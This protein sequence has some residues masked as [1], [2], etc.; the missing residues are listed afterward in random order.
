MSTSEGSAG[1]GG[2]I[3]LGGGG[4]GGIYTAGNSGQGTGG[5]LG[6]DA[7]SAGAGGNAAG[8]AGSAGSAGGSGGAGATSPGI[9]VNP[10]S[11]TLAPGGTQTFSCTVTGLQNK[12]C[13]WSVK[14]GATGGSV[15]TGGVYAAP[16]QQGTYHVVAASH[17]D[18]ALTAT[19]TV[20]VPAPATGTPGQ[21]INVTPANASPTGTFSCSNYGAQ[22]MQRD[23]RRPSDLYTEFNCQ[24]IWKSTDYGVTWT[25]PINTGA[26]GA[27]AGDCAGGITIPP[28]SSAS[29]PIIYEACI[30]GAGTGF[31]AST[32]GGVDWTNYMVIP[33]TPGRQDLYPP[34]VDPHDDQH[35]LMAGHENNLL[36]ETTDG[37][38][39][40]RNITMASGMQMNGGTAMVFFIDTGVA[41]TTAT[42]WLW[43]AQVTGGSIGTWRT[44]DAGATWTQVDKN[45]HPHGASQIYQPATSGVVYMAGVYAAEGWGV[46]RSEDYGATWKSAGNYGGESIVFGTPKNVYA[47]AGGPTVSGPGGGQDPHL[48]VG[49]QP[50]TNTWTM[51]GTPADMA[52]DGAAQATVT[53]DGTHSIIVLGAWN[54]GLWRYIEP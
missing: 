8:A 15:T 6:R 50:G 43:L 14:E 12:T 5:S 1:S 51:Q 18:P 40:W 28:N 45:E 19:A 30:R 41:A 53:S 46:V 2:Q 36:V 9:T 4:G 34:V 25:G 27:K 49:V 13:D 11:A 47:M 38:K 48:E 20:V 31:W 39:T 35:L 21:W 23:P 52:Q 17:M 54:S 24:G 16:A 3:A 37:G 10:P 44:T 42:T 26:N 22:T 33:A 29:P 7:G 32:N